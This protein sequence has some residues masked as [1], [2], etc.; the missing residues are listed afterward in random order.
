[1]DGMK[2]PIEIIERAEKLRKTINH[3][4]HLYHVL[5]KEEISQ[6]A[7]DSL[8]HELAQLEE[9]YP[10]IAAPDS[11]TQRIG[12]KPLPKFGKV[13]HA[14]RQWSFNDCFSEEE[15]RAFDNRVRR[16]LSKKLGKEPKVEYVSELKIDGFKVVLTYENGLLKAAA[17]RGDGIVGED[18]TQNVKTIESIP[19]RLQENISVV[20]EGEIWM[21]RRDFEKLNENQKKKGGIIYANPR[22]VS[23]GSIRQLDPKVAASRKL[24]SF[25]YDLAFSSKT[26]PDTQEEELKLLKNLGFKVNGNFKLCRSVEEAISYWKEWDKK[27]EDMPYWLDGIVVKVNERRYQEVLGYTGKS[28]RYAIAFKFAAEEATTVV[29]NIVVQVGRTGALTPVAHLK[30][31]SIA[32]STVS[33]A[34]LHNEDEIGRLDVRIGDTV[35]VR[36]AGDIIP[37]IVE[38]VKGLRVGK[39]KIFRMPDKCPI[40]RSSVRKT[41]IGGGNKTSAAHYCTNKKCF[42]QEIE[43][44]IHFVSRKALNIEGLGEKIVEQLV[45]EGLVSDL[46]DFFELEEGD[47]IPLER[48]AEKSADNLIK[49]IDVSK[50]ILL[51]KFIY[52][53]GIRHAG[54]ETARLIAN[55]FGSFQKIKETTAKELSKVEGIGDIVARSIS[56][57]FG[58]KQ[59]KRLIE[60]LLKHIK[61][62]NP[63]K[64]FSKNLPLAGKT[65][66]LTGTLSSLSREEAK[67]EIRKLGGSISSSMSKKT[68]FFVAGD[69]PGRKLAKARSL[70][71]KQIS[72]EGFLELIGL[73]RKL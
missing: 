63:P 64:T 42:A 44:M 48:F 53:L 24:D 16:E 18:V 25:I 26:I 58:D 37:E 45:E 20:V 51:Y 69:E 34:T 57:W 8:K 3:H 39:E 19:L 2:T 21:S 72:E 17:T 61:I 12:G 55:H 73:E 11:P 50:N 14:V 46:A 47:L 36:K 13:K 5:D 38:V 4:R 67:E 30:P 66:V 1:M 43:K 56:E 6:A 70:G 33:R 62:E 22:N 10:E 59:N 28:P 65:F 7:L 35:I 68:D 32:G 71:I 15:I 27:N 23:A 40:C 29:E 54:E 9:R 31:V 52:A 41:N 60:K 49:A